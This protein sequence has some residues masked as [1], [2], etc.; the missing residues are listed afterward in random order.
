MTVFIMG[1]KNGGFRATAAPSARVLL[2]GARSDHLPLDVPMPCRLQLLTNPNVTAAGSLLAHKVTKFL[3]T[4]VLG[5]TLSSQAIKRI[6][7]CT[8]ATDLKGSNDEGRA[9]TWRSCGCCPSRETASPRAPSRRLLLRA[10]SRHSGNCQRNPSRL[11]APSESR[12]APPF[13]HSY[14]LSILQLCALVRLDALY[15]RLAANS[16][17]SAGPELTQQQKGVVNPLRSADDL[18]AADEDVVRVAV[19][20]ICRVRHRVEGPDLRDTTG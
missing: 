4:I 7:C 12:T 2:H 18:L 5:D 15:S 13:L 1:W 20:L 3:V 6:H 11:L 8:Q 16:S 10:V 14:T 9:G 17:L 19:R